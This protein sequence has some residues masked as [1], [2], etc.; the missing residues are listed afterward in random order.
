VYEIKLTAQV[1]ILTALRIEVFPVNP[2]IAQHSPGL[3]FIVDK[4]DAWVVGKDG[5]EKQI[6]FRDF[7]PELRNRSL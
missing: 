5:R 1:G 4:M 2:E 7:V 6:A 3:G